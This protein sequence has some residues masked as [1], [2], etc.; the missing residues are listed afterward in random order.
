MTTRLTLTNI[1]VETSDIVTIWSRMGLTYT[2][3]LQ[4]QVF[5]QIPFD[6]FPLGGR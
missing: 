1:S 6:S 4:Y 3:D 5:F 2:T